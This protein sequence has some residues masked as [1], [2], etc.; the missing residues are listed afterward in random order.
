MQ[1]SPI[2]R[3]ILD[4]VYFLFGSL[5][6]A[7]SVNV[8]T[9]PNGI[10]PGG[11]TGAAILLRT[12]TGLPVGLLNLLINIPLFWWGIR[13]M[14]ARP[15]AKSAVAVIM[16]S[17]AIDLTAG[18]LP[19]YR[20]DPMLISIFG[21]VLAGVGLAL[22]FMRG[23]TTGGTDLAATLL[24]RR[25]RHISLGRLILCIDLP[26]VLCSIPVFGNM[27]S[28]MYALIVIFLTTKVIDGVL[29][30]TDAGT[31]KLIFIISPRTQEI[32]R[33]I[34]ANLVRGVTELRAR[35]LYRA[36]ALDAAGRRAARRGLPCI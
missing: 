13:A 11:A 9:A 18:L 20:G 25:L 2:A 24:A 36:G 10:A 31:G 16:T 5:L 19:P 6:F 4:G 1:R 17:I 21:G 26:I 32:K 14:G 27:E 30:G 35:Q 8:F 23:G 12:L 29:Y 28:P 3:R 15:M 33:D 34:H 22:I 7:V